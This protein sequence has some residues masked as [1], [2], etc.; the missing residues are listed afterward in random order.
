MPL[1][2][3][4]IDSRDVFGGRRVQLLRLLARQLD[5]DAIPRRV[6]LD[7]PRDREPS[8]RPGSSLPAP[9]H[10]RGRSPGFERVVSDEARKADSC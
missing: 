5:D 9:H 2:E 6:R 3:T 10:P 4:S 7:A 1:R 8:R